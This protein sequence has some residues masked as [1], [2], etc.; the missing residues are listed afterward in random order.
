[1]ELPRQP[2]E[3]LLESFIRSALVRL[4]PAIRDQPSLADEVLY[5][6]R[7]M[8]LSVRTDG[9]VRAN[10]EMMA[11]LRGDRTMPFGPNHEH[12]PIRLIDFSP[13]DRNEYVV[14][15]QFTFRAG[16]VERRADLVLFINGF[17]VVV[18]EAKTP[19]RPAVT[20]VD[21]AA[22]LHSDYERSVPE[23]FVS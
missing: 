5:K 15:T 6:I 20:W 23:L 14:T 8:V 4:N 21:G 17:P 10:E 9:L 13:D 16:S 11:W 18:G 12:V 19:V 22:Q 2:H 3:A 1:D 7:A